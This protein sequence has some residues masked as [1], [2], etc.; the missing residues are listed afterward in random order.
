MNLAL[1]TSSPAVVMRGVTPTMQTWSGRLVPLLDPQPEDID[2]A[3]IA[4]HLAK[5]NRYT[6]ATRDAAYSIAQHSVFVADL[7]PVEVK[8]YALLH[9]GEEAYVGDSS[10]PL[11]VAMRIV[12][13]QERSPY[14]RIAARFDHVI[15]LAAG[16]TWPVPPDIKAAIRH[17]DLVALATEKRDFMAP[18]E[19]DWPDLPPPATTRL[20]ALTWERAHD[21]FLRRFAEVAK[22]FPSILALRRG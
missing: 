2:I 14:D 9:D 21:L 1:A 17:A 6:G 22:L 3:D 16:L 12:A 18:C 11:K 8:P 19:E 7:V 10:S 5:L 13:Q 4:E 20:R 15:H